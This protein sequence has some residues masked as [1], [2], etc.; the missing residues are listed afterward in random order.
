LNRLAAKENTL[1]RMK[2]SGN[3]ALTDATH[4]VDGGASA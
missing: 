1:E 3:V 2:A 4:K